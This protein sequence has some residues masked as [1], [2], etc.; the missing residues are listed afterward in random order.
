MPPQSNNDYMQLLSDVIKKQ[1]VIL[2]PDITLAKAR[3][4]PGLTVDAS[5]TVTQ[6]SGEPQKITQ[7]LIDQFVQLSGLIVKKTMEPLLA[8]HTAA[9]GTPMKEPAKPAV[10]VSQPV[11]PAS[12]ASP[13]VQQMMQSAP[14]TPIPP[15]TDHVQ[16]VTQVPP[17]T[18]TAPV[19]QPVPQLLQ[20][21][22]APLQN[23]TPM[24]P[25]VPAQPTSIPMQQTD[26][27]QMPPPSEV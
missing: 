26:S 15:M 5:G 10:P 11:P 13:V 12:Q 22:A 7:N 18:A 23:S 14:I 16:N 27:V 24:S 25:P 3:N 17:M 8:Y 6:I 2:G 9:D 4:V 21:Q 19:Q 1:I 20:Q